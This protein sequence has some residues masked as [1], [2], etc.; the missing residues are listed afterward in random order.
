MAVVERGMIAERCVCVW[1]HATVEELNGVEF[2]S[3]SRISVNEFI[4]PLEQDDGNNI[5]PPLTPRP[6]ALDHFSPTL[7]KALAEELA[8]EKEAHELTRKDA[9]T[10]VGYF[11]TETFGGTKL[12]SSARLQYSKPS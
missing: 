11:H 2:L 9:A 8:K 7:F 1:I 5:E 3:R 6:G 4:E 12:T 10:R